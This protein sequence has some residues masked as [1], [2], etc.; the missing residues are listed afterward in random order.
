M[1]N[2]NVHG[3]AISSILYAPLFSSDSNRRER[4]R[5]VCSRFGAFVA[6]LTDADESSDRDTQWCRLKEECGIITMANEQRVGLIDGAA[7]SSLSPT[8]H[9]CLHLCSQWKDQLA[10]RPRQTGFRVFGMITYKPD[11]AHSTSSS[12]PYDAHLLLPSDSSTA[13]VLGTNSECCFIG[14]SICCER[15][16]ILQLRMKR[17]KEICKLYIITDSPTIVTPGLLC[18]EM[19]LE[20]FTLDTPI[21]LAS[22]KKAAE[23]E[24]AQITSNANQ[25]QAF[26]VQVSSLRQLY[27]Y[28]SLYLHVSGSHLLSH[29]ATY[30][31]T[32]E[33]FNVK[34]ASNAQW[35]GLYKSV[36][37][38]TKR[39][40]RTALHPIQYCAGVLFSD[41]NMHVDHMS[42]LLEYGW[43]L[44]AIVKLIPVLEAK[45][46]EQP[47][48]K[49]ELILFVDQFGILHSPF[50]PAR[51]H[52]LEGK[53]SHIQLI[54]HTGNNGV[55]HGCT[56]D[57]LTPDIPGVIEDVL[58]VTSQLS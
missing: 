41:G 38:G 11:T 44:D 31:H 23:N 49:A 1:C 28:P 9:H 54:F 39:D 48:V 40:H 20:F 10:E 42:K 2:V 24:N 5:I 55:L 43:S 8:D 15:T 26:D 57:Q 12:H 19:L 16:A 52:L 58:P 6:R 34:Y 47:D 13:Y 36:I 30:A 32:M 25:Q 18:R 56:I 17:Y 21:I 33:S 22:V 35:I 46:R 27:P 7:L 51:A 53:F 50:A 37:E 14:S 45:G 4:N 29:G 3:A